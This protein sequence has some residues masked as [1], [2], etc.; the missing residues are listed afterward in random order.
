MRSQKEFSRSLTQI[1]LTAAPID[2][3]KIGADYASAENE[4]GVVDQELT[5]GNYYAQYAI[6]NIK[7]GYMKGYLRPSNLS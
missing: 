4:T 1:Q 3:L 6:G 7:V 2:G 5:G